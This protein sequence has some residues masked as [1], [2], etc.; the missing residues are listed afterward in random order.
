MTIIISW[1]LKV[2]V[3]VLYQKD[4]TLIFYLSWWIFWKMKIKINQSSWTL[5]LFLEKDRDMSWNQWSIRYFISFLMKN[6]WKF[7]DKHR[8]TMSFS[9]PWE[10]R[11]SV[12]L[13]SSK[14]SIVNFAKES[15]LNH[16]VLSFTT[17]PITKISSKNIF[18]P[19]KSVSTVEDRQKDKAKAIRIKMPLIFTKD[20]LKML[21]S[22][23]LCY[24]QEE[25]IEQLKDKCL[26][27]SLSHLMVLPSKLRTL[28]PKSKDL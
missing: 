18:T 14:F 2:A 12:S 1:F 23:I 24:K 26:L 4:P 11:W 21:R 13:T 9:V 28:F 19:K 8:W 5:N 27:I 7:W 22:W 25:D 3:S 16:F 15:I 10:T 20:H 6:S 17:F